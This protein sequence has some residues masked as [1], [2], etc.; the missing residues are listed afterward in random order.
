MS[1]E[2]D[3]RRRVNYVF[4]V[5]R[6]SDG[7]SMTEIDARDRQA[8]GLLSE[9]VTAELGPASVVAREV[10][11]AHRSGRQP[12]LRAARAAF[13]ALPG[14]TPVLNGRRAGRRPRNRAGG[15]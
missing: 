12:D 15:G 11:R 4:E 13:A 3:S 10:S 8:L 7:A 2:H 1:E 14:R 5:G 6:S 9:T